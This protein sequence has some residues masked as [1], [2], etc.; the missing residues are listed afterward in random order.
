MRPEIT[1]AH[2]YTSVLDGLSIPFFSLGKRV[3]SIRHTWSRRETIEGHPEWAD[4]IRQIRPG[5]EIVVNRDDVAERGEMPALD[6]KRRSA[7]TSE[8]SGEGSSGTVDVRDQEHGTGEHITS[9]EGRKGQMNGVPLGQEQDVETT[10]W[11]EGHHLVIERDPGNGEEV[12]LFSYLNASP[13]AHNAKGSSG[14]HQECVCTRRNSLSVELGFQPGRR[15]AHDFRNTRG[16]PSSAL[17][18][19][20]LDRTR[21]R[22][23]WREARPN[24]Q[25]RKQ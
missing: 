8:L 4:Q 20:A 22:T 15:Q 25:Q 24:A 13:N 1:L 18:A 19:F 11:R 9:A 5:E 2:P 17:R 21:G 16:R 14:S 23:C 12:R 10:E 7:P 3:H 6:E